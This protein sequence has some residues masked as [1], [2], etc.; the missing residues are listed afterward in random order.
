MTQ[1]LVPI[2]YRAGIDLGGTKME[3]AVLALDG[4]LT[5]RRRVPTPGSY[6]K[7]LRTARDLVESAEAELGASL[8]VGLCFPGSIAPAS[9]T[10]ENCNAFYLNG[11][12]LD[13]DLT[14]ALGREV[15]VANDANCF[16]LSE[17]ADG[18]GAGSRVVFGVILGSG[19]GGGLV[20]DG[21]IVEG[22]HGIGGEWGHIPL[23]WPKANETLACW[24]GLGGC[25]EMYLA[26]PG[27]AA[28][29]DGVGSRDA[30]QLPARAAAGDAAAQAALNRHVDRLAR[31]L[32]MV[33]AI[34]DPDVLVLGGGL[35]NMD[36]LY[37]Q[38]PPLLTRYVRTEGITTPVVKNKHGDSSGVRGAAWLW[39]AVG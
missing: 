7:V 15:R 5:I 9:R 12:P 35:S 13:R 28:D 32:G 19:L 29:C 27:L 39:P 4:S 37:A 21:K 1:P 2:G 10:V 31:G 23:P 36:H 33:I 24:C 16:A 14:A 3:I 18:A 38:V 26:G 25:L 30:S 20:V 34:V 6:E 22:R 8:T 17:S 11:K